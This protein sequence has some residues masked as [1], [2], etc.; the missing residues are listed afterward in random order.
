MQKGKHVGGFCPVCNIRHHAK[1]HCANAIQ[2]RDLEASRAVKRA[3]K[4]EKARNSSCALNNRFPKGKGTL[5]RKPDMDDGSGSDGDGPEA[6]PEDDPADMDANLDP[7]LAIEVEKMSKFASNWVQNVMSR[8]KFEFIFRHLHWTNTFGMTPAEKTAKNKENGFWQVASF[9]IKLSVNFARY[10]QPGQ[11]MD[12]DEM[13]IWFK[14]RHRCR[15]FNPNKPEKWHFKA[16]CLN[17]SE[18]GYVHR[19]YMYQGSSEVRPAGI[20]ATLFPT[21]KLLAP[22]EYHDKNHILST[23]NWFTQLA[24]ALWCR[25]RGIHFNGTIKTNRKGVP[26]EGTF[27]YKGANVRQRGEMSCM[28]AEHDDHWFYFTAWMDS[29]PVHMLSTYMGYVGQVVRNTKNVLTG[30]YVALTLLRPTII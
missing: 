9:L 29:K 13:C 30:V 27:P 6:L 24:S 12:I 5:K 14:G 10:Y 21:T 7:F 23:D 18:T 3:D 2:K 15:C 17:C 19:F 25:V 4:A 22:E 11:R 28:K 16:F 1:T 26:R 8:N 20:A